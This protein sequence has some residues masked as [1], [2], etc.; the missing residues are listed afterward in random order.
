MTLVFLPRRLA[1]LDSGGLSL[2]LA[3]RLSENVVGLWGLPLGIGANLRVNGRDVLAPMAVEE[4]SVVAGMS[5]GALLARAGGGFFCQADPALMRGQLQVL[6]VPDI[7]AACA[8]LAA[9]RDALS[10]QPLTSCTPPSPLWAGARAPGAGATVASRVGQMLIVEATMDVR[11][12]MGANAVNTSMEAAA[13]LVER[14]TGGRVVARILS[15]LADERLARAQCEVPVQALAT[16]ALPGEAVAQRIVQVCAFAEVDAHRAAT[17]NKGIMNGI[18]AVAVA[19]GNDWRALEAGA[20]AY[21]CRNG[22]YAPLS[23]WSLEGDLLVGMLELPLAVGTVGGATRAHPLAQFNLRLMGIAHVAELAEVMAAVG[24][25]Q[26]LAA[27]RALATEGIQRGH[28]RLHARRSKATP[29]PD[30][31]R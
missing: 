21:A 9:G 28:M 12:A 16:A 27:L 31:Q 26:S 1:A 25:A 17:H 4:P 13:P 22:A 20:H 23:T 8:A 11:D 29:D 14:L 3:D 6:D 7:D 2:E 10:P 30:A 18:D 5:H 24:L 19:T 15:N